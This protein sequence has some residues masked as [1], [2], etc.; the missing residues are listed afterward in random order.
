LN[1]FQRVIIFQPN[2]RLIDPHKNTDDRNVLSPLYNIF[3]P[4]VKIGDDG[5]YYGALAKS[6]TVSP[7][8]QN[9]VFI[10]RDSVLFH[11]GERFSSADVK[12]SIEG[13]LN[14]D[15]EGELG[16]K[17]I[18]Q[19]YLGNTR[20]HTPDDLTVIISTPSPMADLLDFLVKFPIVQKDTI[21]D[22]PEKLIGTGAFTLKQFTRNHIE[23]VAFENYWGNKPSIK[24]LIWES[25][26]D[27]SRRIDALL[28]GK[29]DLITV[30]PSFLAESIQRSQTG[31]LETV[32]SNVCTVFMC[33]HFNGICTDRRIRQA[34][35]YGL[36]KD[37]IIEKV[38]NGFAHPL[39]GP[40]TRKHF[41]YD[42]ETPAYQYDPRKASSLL[43]E[44]GYP[45]GID[46]VLDIPLIHPDESPAVAEC[47]A[48]QYN[49][50]G[51][52]TTI[53]RFSDRNNYA[54]M[55]RDKRIDDACCFDSSPLST[56][57]V[58]SDKF[59]SGLHGAWWQGYH[60]HLVDELIDQTRVTIDDLQRQTIYKKAYRIINEDA[61]WIFLQNPVMIWGINRSLS[62]WHPDYQG[63]TMFN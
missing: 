3:E 31:V 46:L 8:A 59:H 58:F 42:P 11:N 44:A 62:G 25:E 35:N 61:P 33:N 24:E 57:Q 13:I 10:L 47:M 12:A 17:G 51:I 29:A 60:N 4:L 18:Y 41:G 36:N 30:V 19:G 7:D 34:L 27:P 50:I 26:P 39:N 28:Q 40:L 5:K 55:V 20:I 52:R 38:M 23:M 14:P 45:N 21:R 6:W 2:I 37:A 32:E 56:Y 49:R 1:E 43:A 16:T 15:S 53:K 54:L 22:S 48:E 9:W 63:F